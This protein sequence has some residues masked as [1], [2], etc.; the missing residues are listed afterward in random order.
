MRDG[1]IEQVGTPGEIYDRRATRSSPI[2]SG[3]RT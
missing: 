1:V 3:R 2:S